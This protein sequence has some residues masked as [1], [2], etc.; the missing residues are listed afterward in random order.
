MSLPKGTVTIDFETFNK[1]DWAQTEARVMSEMVE[2]AHNAAN[3]TAIQARLGADRVEEIFTA[4]LLVFGPPPTRP[5]TPYGQPSGGR[6]VEFRGVLETATGITFSLNES[7]PWYKGY[8]EW[9]RVKEDA[10]Y[11]RR[12]Q[13]SL[14]T[15]ES[16]SS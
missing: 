14:G 10:M 16:E 9:I 8:Y 4:I 1:I 3:C 13:E 7:L 5:G 11:W 2:E 12:K 6:L 15:G